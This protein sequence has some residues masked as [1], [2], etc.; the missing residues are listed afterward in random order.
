VRSTVARLLWMDTELNDLGINRDSLFAGD[1]DTPEPRPYGVLRWGTTSPGMD[2]SRSRVL[3][4]WF[5]D[6]PNDY[7]RIDSIIHRVRQIL[8]GTY[9]AK[10]EIGWITDV[11]WLTDSDDLTDDATR[12]IC[13]NSTFTIVGSG[14]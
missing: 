5:H 13:R 3:T 4:V 14:L 12:T 6:E 2:V 7:T 11:S 8:E 10:T 9:A 1:V